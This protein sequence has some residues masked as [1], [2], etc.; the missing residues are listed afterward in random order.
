MARETINDE[1]VGL[2]SLS[3]IIV[4]HMLD[5]FTSYQISLAKSIV[6]E[7]VKQGEDDLHTLCRRFFKDVLHTSRPQMREFSSY[8]DYLHFL[9]EERPEMVDQ[10]MAYLT[11]WLADPKNKK[12]SLYQQRQWLYDMHHIYKTDSSDIPQRLRRDS[13]WNHLRPEKLFIEAA[14]ST[15][16][17][18]Q[19]ALVITRRKDTDRIIEKIAHRLLEREAQKKSRNNPKKKKI[20]IDDI[21]GLKLIT[22]TKEQADRLC[23]AVYHHLGSYG[24]KPDS[25]QEEQTG[26]GKNGG[27]KHQPPGLDDHYRY[28]NGKNPHYQIKCFPLG[29]EAYRLREVHITDVNSFLA[30]EI[31][32]VKFRVSQRA[33]LQQLLSSHRWVR[34]QFEEYVG[35]GKEI[36]DNLP[37]QRRRIMTVE[38]EPFKANPYSRRNTSAK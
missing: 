3:E 22:Y 28:G 2:L 7:R 14:S 38:R 17:T 13:F 24:L 27:K 11:R 33:E 19:G 36:V 23:Q 4:T 29:D 30:A 21:F 35:R 9:W 12:D 26:V 8:Y 16:R 31:D 10:E 1:N 20:A 6:V 32:H 15:E 34:R 5:D 37:D 18:R 25:W